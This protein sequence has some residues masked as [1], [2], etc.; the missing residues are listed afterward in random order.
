MTAVDGAFNAT[1]EAAIAS[2][3]TAGLANGQHTVF[4]RG[5]DASGNWGPSTARYFT[6]DPNASAALF[7]DDFEASAGN[8]SSLQRYLE[9]GGR[10][11]PALSGVVVQPEFHRAAGGRAVE[12]GQL[13]G[14]GEHQDQ[15]QTLDGPGSGRTGPGGGREQ[16][17]SVRL[18]LGQHLGH[19]SGLGWSFDPA[20]GTFSRPAPNRPAAALGRVW[21]SPIGEEDVG[22]HPSDVT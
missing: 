1:S 8:W 20:A 14:G 9:P 5:Q 12:L 19:Q 10:R 4:V 7:S 21:L 6:I 15:N 18:H 13:L 3:S 2:I 22:R 16:P 11:H 17:L